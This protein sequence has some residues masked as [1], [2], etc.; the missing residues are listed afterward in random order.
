MTPD[1]L[2]EAYLSFFEK[3]G[4][5]RRRSDSLVP[6]DDPTLLFTGAGMNQ[7]KDEFLG[8][9]TASFKRAVTSQKCLRT[10]DIENVG[11]TAG[12]HTFFEMLGN[13][14]F[15]DY[16]KKD[17]IRWAW[18]FST[19][20]LGFD[21]DR[22]RVSV[23]EDDDEAYDAWATGVGVKPEW[24]YRFDEKENFWPANAPA[25][26][27]NGP[28]GPDSEM[29]YDM[30]KDVGCG[31][32]DC[33][34]SCTCDR[35]VEF[36]NLVFTQF[37]RQPDGTLK[38][39]PQKNIDTGM[40]FERTLAI[41]CGAPNNFE[42]PLFM[43]VLEAICKLADRRYETDTDDGRRMRRIADHT[44]AIIFC[45]ADGVLPSNEGRGY[46]ARRLLRIATVD[47]RALGIDQAFLYQL[48]PV[49]T[50]IMQQPYPDVAKRRE[51]IARIV[52][53]EEEKFAQTLD[54]GERL[55]GELEDTY[56]LE[57][58][59]PLPGEELFRLADTYGLPAEVVAMRLKVTAKTTT[60]F[61]A[62]MEKQREMARGSSAMGGDIFVG[63][64][65]GELRETVGATEFTGYE[66]TSGKATVHAIVHG[67]K[68]I[69]EATPETGGVT[70]VFDKTPFYGEQ[71]GQV[72]DAGTL[73]SVG[74]V[75]SVEMAKMSPPHVLHVGKVTKGVLKVGDEVEASVDSPRRMDIA[76]NHTATHLLHEAL[77]QVLG[78][79]T[80]QSGSLVAPDYLRFDFHHFEAPSE[81]QL[82]AIE[83]MVN[84]K[85][86]ENVEVS[87]RETDIDSARKEG[88][89]ALF[90]EKYGD[91]V[92]VVSVGEF[93]KELCG[94]THCGHT[95]DI[96]QFKIIGEESVASG[97]RRITAITG[98]AALAHWR[99][100]EGQ[101]REVASELKTPLSDV[102]KRTAAVNEEL[103]SL[104]KQ[105]DKVRGSERSTQVADLLTG[106]SSVS[107]VKVVIGS[108][109][110]MS[111]K[112]LRSAVD[113]LK[114]SGEVAAV[115][116]SVM[117]L[118][119]SL[120]AYVG[121]KARGAGL[122]A[123]SLIKEVAKVV[124]GGGG[125]R[126]DL[127]QAG[128]TDVSKINDALE[129]AR[130]LITEELTGI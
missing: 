115:L 16:F 109:D 55:I 104:R 124:G 35:Y 47:G 41:L 58:W 73:T 74:G 107:G 64:A 27:P 112:D 85:V 116:A 61:E 65:I 82:Q 21:V 97:I 44:R 130:K 119:V 105:L 76:R 17:A 60:Q 75:V 12:H 49:I 7:F 129:L 48:V 86:M 56:G 98:R 110:G 14:S 72:G 8:R 113:V 19:D 103:K 30:G 87:T 108:F 96:G 45:I 90:G 71:G 94:G 68:L 15:G 114:N 122:K 69:D 62:L 26:G 5:A 4:H 84:E 63:G 1:E 34:P 80:E 121:E 102:V 57:G 89:K 92:R 11:R 32:P 36:W 100:M 127:A 70:V 77:R 6:T 54:S 120:I 99:K 3:R 93:S 59:K 118:K 95:G 42:T 126:P 28:C 20:V 51:T 117:G 81:E 18:E 22:L 111:P 23:Y 52:K 38:P 50:S 88:A 37:D 31:R 25:K 2:R 123:G 24:I 83:D 46:V 125:G 13:F 10:G 66:G 9:G 40:G 29:F 43:P 128:G 33:D 79:H 91:K 67:D 53:A 78:E 106:A 101:L 39:L